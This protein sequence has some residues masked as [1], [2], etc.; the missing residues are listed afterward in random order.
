MTS[1]ERGLRAQP[2]GSAMLL[3]VVF[4]VSDADKNLECCEATRY[5]F[6]A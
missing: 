6:L 3:V 2:I 4:D 1:G 5:N